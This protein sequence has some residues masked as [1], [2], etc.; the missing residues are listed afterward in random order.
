MNLQTKFS[1]GRCF[2]IIWI[3]S[4]PLSWSHNVCSVTAR[5]ERKMKTSWSE[6]TLLPLWLSC[7]FKIKVFATFFATISVVLMFLSLNTFAE[8]WSQSSFIINIREFSWFSCNHSASSSNAILWHQQPLGDSGLKLIVI[9]TQPLRI[10]SNSISMWLEMAQWN[11]NFTY[12]NA[13]SQKT[14]AYI[15]VQL[16]R[17]CVSSKSLIKPLRQ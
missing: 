14:A 4:S 12:Q 13:D 8:H 17:H 11:L 6:I 16:S 15:T 5:T 9:P 7:M 3:V 10:H 2:K 1:R